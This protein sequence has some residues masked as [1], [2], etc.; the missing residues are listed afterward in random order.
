MRE[1]G[2]N[3][4]FQAEATFAPGLEIMLDGVRRAARRQAYV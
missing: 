1:S 3:P 4:W 2:F